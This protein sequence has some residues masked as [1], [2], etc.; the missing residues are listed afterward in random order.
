MRARSRTRLNTRGIKKP[1]VDDQPV[2]KPSTMEKGSEL[3][4]ISAS[5]L[6]LTYDTVDANGQTAA[7][8]ENQIGAQVRHEGNKKTYVVTGFVWNGE[9]DTWN[10]VMREAFNLRAVPVTRPMHQ[11]FGSRMDENARYANYKTELV[12]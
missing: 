8:W 10:I 9:N 3:L 1:V 11:F 12:G 7:Q 2:A 4:P 6:P 5:R